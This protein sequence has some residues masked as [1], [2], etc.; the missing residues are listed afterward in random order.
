MTETE[1]LQTASPSVVLTGVAAPLLNFA[2]HL[3]LIHELLC[4][5]PLVITSGKDS[6]HVAGSL[7]SEGLAVD[8]RTKDKSDA[9]NQL[10][11]M[12]LAYA[13]PENEIAVFDERA[14]PDAPHIHIEYH[15]K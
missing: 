12:V 6:L 7:H 1:P 8:L 3:A 5:A 14:L 10:F 13:G 15:G 2:Q 11:L 9:A 4:G